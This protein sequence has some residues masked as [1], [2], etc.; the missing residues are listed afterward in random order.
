MVVGGLV[1]SHRHDGMMGIPTGDTI[2][3]IP[4]ILYLVDDNRSIKE[5]SE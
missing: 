5:V 2:Y 4:Y 3:H 1:F